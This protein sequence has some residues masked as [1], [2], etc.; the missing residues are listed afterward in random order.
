M[1]ASMRR[2]TGR[3]GALARGGAV[4]AL[5]GLS[6]PALA[7]EPAE[8]SNT[9][10]AIGAA[11]DFPVSSIG[12]APQPSA[13]HSRRITVNRVP[14]VGRRQPIRG[15]DADTGIPATV[16]L[17]G[18]EFMSFGQVCRLKD[19]QQIACGS[20][21]KVELVNRIANATMTCFGPQ[22]GPVVRCTIGDDDL[23]DWIVRRGIGKPTRS[24]LH[25][26]AMRE[27]REHGRGMWADVLITATAESP[28]RP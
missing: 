19:G 4:A 22:A 15:V 8:A 25:G 13:A 18:V 27:A 2:T 24:G 3:I 17:P 11:D 20:R 28:V 9:A 10:S 21:A 23:A 14:F 16:A 6:A 7:G 1:E 12:A 26:D 5:I